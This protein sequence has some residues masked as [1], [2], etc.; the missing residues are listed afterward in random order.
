FEVDVDTEHQLAAEWNNDGIPF[1]VFYWNGKQ[2]KVEASYQTRGTLAHVLLR[3]STRRAAYV[4]PSV[5]R[6]GGGRRCVWLLVVGRS[7][8]ACDLVGCG[9]ESGQI[10]YPT[11]RV[12][13]FFCPPIHSTPTRLISCFIQSSSFNLFILRFHRFLK[14][15]AHPPIQWL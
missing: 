7:R 14:W 1:S 6:Y 10:L 13:K 15:A 5:S 8:V 2:I 12:A 3:R 4:H 11:P 9:G